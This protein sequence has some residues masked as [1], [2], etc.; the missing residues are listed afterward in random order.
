M[1]KV[2]VG[3]VERALYDV[4][5]FSPAQI[6]S[7][8]ERFLPT[9]FK[10]DVEMLLLAAKEELQTVLGTKDKLGNWRHPVED[11]NQV[12]PPKYAVEELFQSKKGRKYR[13]TVHAKAVLEKVTDVRRLLFGNGGQPQCPVFKE[14]IDWI[15]ERT[16]VPAY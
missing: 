2:Q 15:S 8:V 13:D 1:K 4:Y 9:A 11:Q 10:H 14:M 3:L 16:G 7:A 12:K 6:K 5:L